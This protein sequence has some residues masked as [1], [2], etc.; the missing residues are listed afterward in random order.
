MLRCVPGVSEK[1]LSR[2]TLEVRDLLEVSNLGRDR[3][4]ALVGREVGRQVWRF[5][6]RSVF[7]DASAAAAGGVG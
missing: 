5:F 1:N 6:N 2:L 7:E 4:D 3:L